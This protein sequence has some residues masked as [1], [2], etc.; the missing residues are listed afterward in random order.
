MC[1]RLAT[2]GEAQSP[3]RNSSGSCSRMSLSLQGGLREGPEVG[4]PPPY[5]DSILGRVMV[6]GRARAALSLQYQDS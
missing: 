3:L 6:V 4:G 2:L 1:V 5:L